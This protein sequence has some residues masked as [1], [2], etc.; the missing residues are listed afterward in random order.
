MHLALTE[1]RRALPHCLPN[2]PVGAVLTRGDAVLAQGHTQPPGRPH[3]EAMV[4]AEV[5]GDLS[6]CVLHVTL[7]PCSFHG[8]TPSCA[9]ALIDRGIRFVSVAMVD[10]D[11][12]NAGKGL[13][14][15]R[16]AGIAVFLG[17]CA[18][19]ARRELGD[20]LDLPANRY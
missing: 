8:R 12:R 1:G 3:A 20:H 14:M 10:P 15:L 4:L 7:E 2:P 11:P 13:E 9:Q 16:A 5:G 18:L 6:D 19:E 17:T